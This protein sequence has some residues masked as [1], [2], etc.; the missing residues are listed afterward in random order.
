MA[1]GSA[2]GFSSLIAHATAS[3]TLKS[4]RTSPSGRTACPKRQ[5]RDDRPGGQREGSA[6]PGEPHRRSTGHLGQPGC[7]EKP[8][9]T[10]LHFVT[11]GGDSDLVTGHYQLGETPI[12]VDM[13]APEAVKAAVTGRTNTL[14]WF[15]VGLRQENYGQG[16]RALAV[17]QQGEKYARGSRARLRGKLFTTCSW[18]RPRLWRKATDYAPRR[19]TTRRPRVPCA[20]RWRSIR[21][22][23]GRRCSWAHCISTGRRPYREQIAW[24]ARIG[25]KL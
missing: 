11:T 9:P 13:S 24:R 3:R 8:H 4:K 2:N 6:R 19:R 22:W 1:T 18:D 25:S 14:F 10:F 17:L 23:C 7:A 21:A 16:G 20:R 5:G 15:T 12:L